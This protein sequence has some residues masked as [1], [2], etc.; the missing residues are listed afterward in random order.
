M[1][2]TNGAGSLTVTTDALTVT[3]GA[4]NSVVG[5]AI[6]VHGAADDC[7]SQPAGNSGMRIA[8]AVIAA[9]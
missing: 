6:I 7:T 2:V 4:A 5:K 3:P 8:C 9:N 1:M